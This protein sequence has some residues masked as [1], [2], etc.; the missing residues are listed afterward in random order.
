MKEIL[1]V[2]GMNCGHCESKV[3][4]FVSEVEGVK[5]IKVNLQTKQ[6]EVEFESPATLDSIKEAILDSGF[7][8]A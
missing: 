2:N 7:E 1:Q 3:K 6:V 8:V 4:S 5:D